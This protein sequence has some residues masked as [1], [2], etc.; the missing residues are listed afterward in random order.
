MGRFN[1]VWP[2]HGKICR[3]TRKNPHE[4]SNDSDADLRWEKMVSCPVSQC[5]RPCYA[6][7]QNPL[8]SKSSTI[9]CIYIIYEYTYTYTYIYMKDYKGN[10]KMFIHFQHG[11]HRHELTMHQQKPQHE[12][13]KFI[14]HT[15][16]SSPSFF[17]P[18]PSM[19]DSI[20]C[21][22]SAEASKKTWGK[23]VMNTSD[24]PLLWKK[25]C[26]IV[27]KCFI[28]VHLIEFE[29]LKF[30]RSILRDLDQSPLALL[31]FSD[32]SIFSPR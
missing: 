32:P 5:N 3:S 23:R 7:K 18:R 4:S 21:R 25:I 26:I 22:G 1:M 2:K 15:S 28:C 6:L 29:L 24:W 16:V 9:M 10:V 31:V 12:L 11:H 27:F 19:F 20:S 30:Q 14:F 13:S 8:Q 17:A